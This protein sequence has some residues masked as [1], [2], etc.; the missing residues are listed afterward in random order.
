MSNLGN[1]IRF[2]IMNK[3]RS[4][5]FIVTSLLFAALISLGANL[6]YL[7]A[8]FQSEKTF[9][10]GI[11]EDPAGVASGLEAYFSR[12]TDSEIELVVLKDRGSAEANEAALRQMV[13]SGEIEGYLIVGE[14]DAYGFPVM[15]YKSED[16]MDFDKQNSLLNGL[17]QIKTERIVAELKLT[18]E[19]LAALHAPVQLDK[20]QITKT[21]D[22]EDPDKSSAESIFA[23]VMLIY[24]LIILLFVAI[25]ITGQLIAT[26]ITAEKS[27]RIMEI[28]VTSVN[29]LTQM[30]GK[31]IGMFLVG[32]SQIALIA[33]AAAVNLSLPHNRAIFQA[34]DID[35]SKLDYMLLV[36][37]LIFYLTGYLLYAT[38]FAA[39]GSIVSRTEELGQ[40]VTPVTMLTMIGYFIAI[41]GMMAPNSSIVTVTSFIPFFSPFIMFLRLGTANPAPWEVW[42]SIGLL[43]LSILV[44]GWLSAK[45]Y[46]TGVLMYGKRPTLKELRKAMK[47]YK[48]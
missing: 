43:L 1:V 22:P 29:P 15:T 35:L 45:I 46:R 10:V 14:P 34:M 27:S 13:Q 18:Q 47:A 19:Q 16:T 44:F 40:A 6:P 23:S 39:V 20:V 11:A 8:L 9:A 37:A 42:L 12:Q 17:M 28:L 31:I 7:I 24:A 33:A 3:L 26:E 21:G 2:T 32:L 36:Y 5:A 41:Y 25:M 4:R 38:L 30:F 48:I